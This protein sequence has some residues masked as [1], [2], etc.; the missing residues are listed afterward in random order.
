MKK[1]MVAAL[2]M[3]VTGFLGFSGT[4]Y[5]NNITIWDGTGA[6]IL[7]QGGEDQEVEPGMV[8]NQSW[9]LEGFFL[10]GTELSMVGGFDFKNGNRRIDSGDIF[11]DIND[12][13]GR[14]SEPSTADGN[15]LVASTFGYDYVFD[16]DLEGE[17]YTLRKL[18]GDSQTWD[19]TVPDNGNNTP[20][21]NPWRY[22]LDESAGDL[23]ED[24]AINIG[25]GYAF[26]L[27]DSGT[28]G[29]TTYSFDGGAGSHYSLTGFD[30]SPIIADM[31]GGPLSFTSH[32]TMGCG[33]DNLMGQGTTPVPEPGMLL[34]VGTAF[35]GFVNIR[36]KRIKRA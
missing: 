13:Y 10:E 22:A 2:A 17:T 16:L 29:A 8:D 6:E 3:G 7:G 33:N 19:V 18:T 28:I 32:F 4:V 27:N 15:N 11:I 12:D 36:R 25:F 34:L 9:D 31:G 30:L 23:H 26:G 35:A 24:L 21:S 20:G 5:A 14:S 1:L